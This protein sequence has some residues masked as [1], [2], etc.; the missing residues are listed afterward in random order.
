MTTE[1]QIVLDREG[2]ARLDAIIDGEEVLVFRAQIKSRIWQLL[3]KNISTEQQFTIVEET[4]EEYQR[5]YN[6][7]RYGRETV[8]PEIR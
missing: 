4:E 8:E 6:L 2:C 5:R 3:L 7:R 1:W